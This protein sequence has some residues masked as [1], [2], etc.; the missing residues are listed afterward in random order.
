MTNENIIT[1]T[2]ENF[3]TEVIQSSKPV[4]VDFYASWC[5]PCQMLRPVIEELAKEYQ[6]R[7]KFCKVDIDNN[8]DLASVHAVMSVPTLM[9]FKE[10]KKVEKLI[11]FNP[12]RKIAQRLNS[13]FGW[14]E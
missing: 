7:V 12:R 14:F 6:S 2:Q 8:K 10:G 13:L 3:E 11:G 4:L 1:L 5:R 9:I